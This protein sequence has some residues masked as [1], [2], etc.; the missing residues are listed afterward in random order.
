MNMI[1]KTTTSLKRYFY[2]T[3][4]VVARNSGMILKMLAVVQLDSFQQI[5]PIMIRLF[6]IYFKQFPGF[7]KIT[8]DTLSC[9]FAPW[10]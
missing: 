5:L 10:F 6:I 2:L 3:H 8:M 1:S 9:L 4:T 7:L